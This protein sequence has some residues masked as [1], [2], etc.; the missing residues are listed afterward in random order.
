MHACMQHR[1]GSAW[2]ILGNELDKCH[3]FPLD[4]VAFD[5][6]V[7]ASHTNSINASTAYCDI[8]QTPE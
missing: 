7:K 3:I 4:K 8:W 2:N 5:V 1:V 6:L